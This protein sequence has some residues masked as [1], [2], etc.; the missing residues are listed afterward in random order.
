MRFSGGRIRGRLLS[1]V[2]VWVVLCLGGTV[3]AATPE[4][5]D[6]AFT[7]GAVAPDVVGVVS[8]RGPYAAANEF[9]YSALLRE[10]VNLG[11]VRVVDRARIE[12]ILE[13]QRLQLTGFVDT[14]TA[15]R[16]GQLLGMRWAFIGQIDELS[17]SWQSGTRSTYG[18]YKA[19]ARISIT[20]I[21]VESGEVVT[22]IQARGT[23][24]DDSNS[25]SARMQAIGSA[26]SGNVA[27][28]LRRLFQL[29]AHVVSVRGNVAYL[30]VG[31]EA[32]V[33]EGTRFR[34]VREVRLKPHPRAEG[35][36]GFSLH[37]VVGVVVVTRVGRGVSEARI[38]RGAGAV[39]PGDQVE[40]DT[41]P[42]GGI[43]AGYR[44]APLRLEDQ[45]GKRVRWGSH[46]LQLRRSTPLSWYGFGDA[47][48]GF[49]LP[50]DG[51]FAFT[52]GLAASLERPVRGDQV[53]A[54]AGPGVEAGLWFQSFQS[55][56]HGSHQAFA[57]TIGLGLEAGISLLV[58]DRMRLE[59]GLAF[60]IP[61]A[62][63]PWRYTPDDETQS[64]DATDLV[65]YPVVQRS[66]FGPFLRFGVKF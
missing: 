33:R 7:W 53:R 42:A 13:E 49:V 15:V 26:F 65:L 60:A 39:S 43:M 17:S 12:E 28:A 37:E 50:S 38:V 48:L 25:E 44:Y 9:A 62:Q 29:Q 31:S 20:V 58:T 6:T 2:A 36:G 16:V 10:L 40:E 54:F 45:F 66:G 61:V 1:T 19:T 14:R 46:E 47:Y 56:Y 51:L 21:D 63:T 5:P 22:V 35:R 18:Y 52:L 30:S 3:F 27:D 24:I 64:T 32:G 41:E 59:G 57:I 34:V 8:F 55:I 23:G 11:R 4:E